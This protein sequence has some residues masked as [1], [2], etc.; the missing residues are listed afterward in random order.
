MRRF[1]APA[2]LKRMVA[3]LFL[4]SLLSTIAGPGAGS[5][6]PPVGDPIFCDDFESGDFAGWSS[7]E[8]SLKVP[9]GPEFQVN[10]YTSGPQY[11]SSV[12][13]D[14]DGDF[15][16]VWQGEFA[17]QGR[18][19][20]AGGDMAGPQFQVSSYTSGGYYASV[21]AHADGKFVAVWSLPA[22][23]RVFAS[24]GM[25][26]SPEFQL[27]DDNG[28]DYSMAA[29]PSGDFIVVWQGGG[30]HSKRFMS[31]GTALG[32]DLQISPDGGL[33]SVAVAA[34]GEFVV[35]WDAALQVNLRGRRFTSDGN[36][37]GDEFQVNSSDIP[38]S[39]AVTYPSVATD[40]DGNFVVVWAVGES[41]KPSI[42]SRFIASNSPCS[43]PIA[44]KASLPPR[45]C[46][47]SKAFFSPAAV[48]STSSTMMPISLA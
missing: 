6:C 9:I 44:R 5:E 3:F 24:D 39:Y 32:D 11:R 7:V 8:L 4:A 15:M 22:R 46:S 28:A 31:D 26:L 37:L 21:A 14:S 43:S 1:L 13:V 48:A 18:L 36:F 2:S 12:A 35:V 23:G 41:P 42:R 30:I 29:A 47:S 19:Y 20:T 34:G 17:V 38:S 33:P 16:V 10:T 40:P 27:F 45:Y 25:P